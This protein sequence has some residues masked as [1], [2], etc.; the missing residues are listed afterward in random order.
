M[1]AVVALLTAMT[2]TP[3]VPVGGG[4]MLQ[5]IAGNTSGG[6]GGAGGDAHGQ[7]VYNCNVPGSCTQEQ[8]IIGG[9][10][11]QGG[12]AN[13]GTQSGSGSSS[14]PA[15]AYGGPEPIRKVVSRCSL[16]IA[17]TPQIEAT[18]CAFDFSA[19]TKMTA[20]VGPSVNG[21]Y[22]YKVTWLPKGDG[23]AQA[24]LQ[25][26]TKS[27]VREL[28]LLHRNGACWTSDEVRVCAWK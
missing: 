27:A 23:T 21:K 10:G 8:K 6:P 17:G 2:A 4:Q 18:H 7:N 11:G 25:G 19:D 26:G 24:W 3:S 9:P 13:G 15:V 5:F 16:V 20:L 14:V 1:L 12:A 28:G 22:T